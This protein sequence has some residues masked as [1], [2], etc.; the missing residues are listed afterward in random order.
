MRSAPSIGLASDRREIERGS[1]SRPSP[2]GP[3]K[4]RGSTPTI[5]RVMPLMRTSRPSTLRSPP[6]SRCQA[7]WVSEHG[8]RR[9]GHEL[10]PLSGARPLVRVVTASTGVRARRDDAER[11]EEARL[12]PGQA[13]DPRTRLVAVDGIDGDVA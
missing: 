8:A 13:R 7:A 12:D 4:S 6:N 1:R 11:V 10:A 5:V 3:T 2:I 9:V